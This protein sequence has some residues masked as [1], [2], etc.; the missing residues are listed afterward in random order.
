MIV[1]KSDAFG[2]HQFKSITQHRGIKMD[3]ERFFQK[4][5]KTHSCW[6]WMASLDHRGYGRF[7]FN[8]KAVRAHRFS[9]ELFNG[10]IQEC[11]T[12]DH[13]CR[14]KKCV[15]P[16]H[17]RT[18]TRA[19]NASIGNKNR[20]KPSQCQRGHEFSGKNLYIDRNGHRKCKTCQNQSQNTRRRALS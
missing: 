6:I 8:K 18:M 13:V 20:E 5:L 14:N 4:V 9:F 2:S 10:P 3:K 16:D 17:L 11:L 12:I 15:N 19:E 7:K 1:P